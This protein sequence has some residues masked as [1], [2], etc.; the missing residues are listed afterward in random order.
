MS[1]V[2][3]SFSPDLG[4]EMVI[5]YSVQ[6]W[7]GKFEVECENDGKRQRGQQRRPQTETAPTMAT[8]NGD[9]ARRPQTVT[10]TKMATA[11]ANGAVNAHGI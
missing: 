6:F 2:K 5:L 10:S 11:T 1:G 4:N 3:R 7:T 8:G 9:P